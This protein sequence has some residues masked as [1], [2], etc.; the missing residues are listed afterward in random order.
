MPW[1]DNP[2]V[3][4]QMCAADTV[5]LKVDKTRFAINCSVS[6]RSKVIVVKVLLYTHDEALVYAH[7]QTRMCRFA[8]K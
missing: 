4:M 5:P 2:R 1:C 8:R 3:L 6:N 7:D